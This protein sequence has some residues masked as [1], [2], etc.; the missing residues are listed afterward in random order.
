MA[1]PIETPTFILADGGKLALIHNGIIEN[2]QALPRIAERRGYRSAS[3]KPIPEVAAHLVASAAVRR[4]TSLRPLRQSANQLHGAFTLLV[5]H[6][7][8]PG[9][10]VGAEA[11]LTLSGGFG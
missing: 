8:Q 5:T 10:V 4:V 2:Y 9:V 6:Q 7:D 11:K 3:A 1:P